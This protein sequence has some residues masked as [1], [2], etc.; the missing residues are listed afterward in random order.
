MRGTDAPHQ[1]GH[2]ANGWK[3]LRRTCHGSLPTGQSPMA[4]PTKSHLL[5]VQSEVGDIGE[6][7]LLGTWVL[8]HLGF[9]M[10]IL[11]H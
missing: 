5:M 3:P 8:I 9:C 1:R 6:D 2:S 7:A 11:I 10:L 4:A